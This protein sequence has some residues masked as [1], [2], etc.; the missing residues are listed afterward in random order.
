MNTKNI[1]NGITHNW[2]V[3]IP[4]AQTKHSIF[5]DPL[6]Y[7]A[8]MATLWSSNVGRTIISRALAN[9]KP[10]QS[11]RTADV[12]GRPDVRRVHECPPSKQPKLSESALIRTFA[13]HQRSVLYRLLVGRSANKV[14]RMDTLLR[15]LS[16]YYSAV[17]RIAF[18]LLLASNRPHGD[19]NSTLRR[20]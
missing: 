13:E 9:N 11:S 10:I 1:F 15:T 20:P 7:P 14:C 2:I 16:D 3:H 12:G 17:R 8:N 5:A 6:P 18:N 19:I 4:S